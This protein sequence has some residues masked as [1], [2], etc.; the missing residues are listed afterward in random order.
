VQEE[1]EEL[2]LK[3]TLTEEFIVDGAVIAEETVN[4]EI[5]VEVREAP[6]ITIVLT[7][8]AEHNFVYHP[9]EQVAKLTDQ[10]V[11]YFASHGKLDP[12]KQYEL[13]FDGN[14]LQPRLT[15]AEAGVKPDDKLTLSPCERPVDG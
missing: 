9:K 12:S 15:L 6:E 14:K 7:S 4:A 5:E 1:R 11:K 13:I 3:E 2:I 8:G 10:A